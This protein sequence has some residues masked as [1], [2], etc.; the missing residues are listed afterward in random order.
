MP[1]MPPS[2]V[3]CS[4]TKTCPMVVRLRVEGVFHLLDTWDM[5]RSTGPGHVFD[6]QVSARGL[7]LQQ[8]RIDWIDTYYAASIE[9][10]L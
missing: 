7:A 9:V 8:L 4:M 3:R 2:S 5:A 10:A 6:G 1:C